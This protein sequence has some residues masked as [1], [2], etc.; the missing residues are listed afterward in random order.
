[1]IQVLLAGGG[2]ME[3]AGQI[4]P[5]LPEAKIAV[6]AAEHSV[7]DLLAAVRAGADGYLPG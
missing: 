3:A 5:Q 6:L 7:D 2:G 1:M 4:S